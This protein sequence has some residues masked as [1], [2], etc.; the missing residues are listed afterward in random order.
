[1]LVHI[2]SPGGSAPEADQIANYLQRLQSQVEVIAV[3]E[4]LVASAA[5]KIFL[6]IDRRAKGNESFR[7]MIH[8]PWGGV[9]G[10]AD[11]IEKYADEVRQIEKEYEKFYEDR[12]QLDADTLSDLMANETY[13]DGEKLSTFNIIN[14][15]LQEES[16]QIYAILKNEKPMTNEDRNFLQSA[17]DEIK[18]FFKKAEITA[19]TIMTN[20]GAELTFPGEMPVE[21]DSVAAPDGTYTFNFAEKS[22][23]ARVE[24]NTLVELTEVEP[25]VPEN[26]EMD[27]LRAENE[28]LKQQLESVQASHNEDVENMKTEVLALKQ[29][30]ETHKEI[31]SKEQPEAKPEQKF[32]E[33]AVDPI[34]ERLQQ[35]R[36]KVNALKTTKKLK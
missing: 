6:T 9:E 31:Q 10:D 26:S 23:T 33:P 24:G 15:T 12:L 35:A 30:V 2:S 17:F 14:H 22:W 16:Q 29:Y 32:E 7:L 36:E 8:N 1:F 3:G 20:E 34:K 5:S 21:G 13:I 19:L 4:G 18:S 25:E 11:Y 28:Q 27:A